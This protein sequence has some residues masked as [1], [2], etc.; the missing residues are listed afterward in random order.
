MN[1]DTLN[2]RNMYEICKASMSDI[3]GIANVQ[4]ICFPKSF[5]VRMGVF[6]PIL[7]HSHIESFI[8]CHPDLFYV[9]KAEGKVVGF[10]YGY[11]SDKSIATN[12]YK[13]LLSRNFLRLR[14]SFGLIFFMFKYI[15]SSLKSRIGGVKKLT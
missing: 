11:G 3:N 6:S 7:L 8:H 13:H 14:P 15:L 9:A 1:Q 4:S 12:Y 5:Y 10:I 2:L